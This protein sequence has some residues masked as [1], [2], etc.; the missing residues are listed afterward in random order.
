MMTKQASFPSK[1][2]KQIKPSLHKSK[3]GGGGGAPTKHERIL[4]LN[5]SQILQVNLGSILQT[6]THSRGSNPSSENLKTPFFGYSKAC[7]F[8]QSS[9]PESGA[10]LTKKLM[11]SPAVK[12]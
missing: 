1:P 6:S 10:S 5:D 8:L 4:S 2:L 11:L 12:G 3:E 7:L 9:E